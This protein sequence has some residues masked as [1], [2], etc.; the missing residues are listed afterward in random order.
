M[1][2]TWPRVVETKQSTALPLALAVTAAVLFWVTIQPKHEHFDY[3][4]R[5]ASA[6]LHGHVG[7]ASNPGSSLNEFVPANGEYYSVFPLGAVLSLLPVALL[8]EVG[9][10]N[11]FPGGAVATVNLGRC[12]HAV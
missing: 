10:I 8:K 9:L 7:L 1:A 2:K 6:L 12:A 11:S 3:T 4:F 5:I